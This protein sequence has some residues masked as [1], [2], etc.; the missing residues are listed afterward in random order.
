MSTK[1]SRARTMRMTDAERLE[2]TARALEELTISYCDVI[3]ELSQ[4]RTV[5]RE[6]ELL[7]Y[8]RRVVGG[9]LT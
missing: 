8:A 1:R 4:Y 5:D 3:A 6:E 2:I 7:E 9:D